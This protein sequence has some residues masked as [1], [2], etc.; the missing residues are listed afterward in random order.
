[1]KRRGERRQ[2]VTQRWCS[3]LLAL[4]RKWTRA[5]GRHALGI[6]PPAAEETATPVEVDVTIEEG[7]LSVHVGDATHPLDRI[8]IFGPNLVVQGAIEPV[9][10]TIA[11]RT[12]FGLS[13][14]VISGARSRRGLPCP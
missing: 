13:S 5:S 9:L 6:V 14:P 12:V 3:P 8:L 7:V 4:S 2:G 1:M 11:E 10:R